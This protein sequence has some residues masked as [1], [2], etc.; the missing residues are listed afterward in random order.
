MRDMSSDAIAT[1]LTDPYYKEQIPEDA[2]AR[3]ENL[4][5]KYA[6]IF[7]SYLTVRPLCKFPKSVS[8]SKR[9]LSRYKAVRDCFR[10]KKQAF[11]SD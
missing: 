3:V 9:E 6:R 10:R 4:L 2:E 11:L 7:N 5:S 1:Y 8:L